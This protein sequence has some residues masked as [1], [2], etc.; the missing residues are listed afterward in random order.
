MTESTLFHTLEWVV[1]P[2]AVFG[3]GWKR[4]RHNWP[5]L[6]YAAIASVY[7]YYLWSE[8]P[9]G[10]LLVLAV[11]LLIVGFLIKKRGLY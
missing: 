11:P 8:G 3:L 5:W 1:V 9:N 4:L 10:V 6:V 2:I 7:S